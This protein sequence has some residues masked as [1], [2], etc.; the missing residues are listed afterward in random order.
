MPPL[1]P[2][3]HTP[4][5][6]AEESSVGTFIVNQL[7]VGS[8]LVNFALLEKHDPVSPQYRGEMMGSNQGGP[9]PCQFFRGQ[10]DPELVGYSPVKAQCAV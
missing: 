9:T 2:F 6:G 3:G 7:L 10:I 5:L 8:H 4:P 1:Y